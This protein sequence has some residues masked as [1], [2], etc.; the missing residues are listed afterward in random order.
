MNQLNLYRSSANVY[1]NNSINKLRTTRIKQRTCRKKYN[2]ISF[3]DRIT[4]DI[5]KQKTR[6]ILQKLI[7]SFKTIEITAS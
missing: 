3:L 6:I 2:S 5:N 4:R 1:R 7:R